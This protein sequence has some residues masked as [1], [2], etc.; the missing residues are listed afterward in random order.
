M[1]NT[2]GEEMKYNK[3]VNMV[4][5][6]MENQETKSTDCSG[7]LRKE[8]RRIGEI[9]YVEYKIASREG[10]RKMMNA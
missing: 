3:L 8:S 4:L 10:K 7:L 5:E 2:N 6:P 9:V 1:Q